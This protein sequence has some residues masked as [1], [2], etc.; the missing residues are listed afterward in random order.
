MYDHYD[1]FGSGCLRALDDERVFVALLDNLGHFRKCETGTKSYNVTLSLCVGLCATTMQWEDAYINES[2]GYFRSGQIRYNTI[3]YC[4]KVANRYFGF[5]LMIRESGCNIYLTLL[6][7]YAYTTAIWYPHKWK[8]RSQSQFCHSLRQ[9]LSGVATKR[10]RA[11]IYFVKDHRRTILLFLD[12]LHLWT[13][14]RFQ[15]K[16]IKE[17]LWILECTKWVKKCLESYKKITWYGYNVIEP[18]I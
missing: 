5:K 9:Y 2:V 16:Q 10:Y 4:C 15:E 18:G 7:T 1:S 6:F 12:L 14:Y 8:N 11:S 3:Q 17:I 13:L